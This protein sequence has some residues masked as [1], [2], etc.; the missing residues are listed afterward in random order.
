MRP[1]S[2][3]QLTHDGY[4]DYNVPVIF[5]QGFAVPADMMAAMSHPTRKKR[6]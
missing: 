4:R 5:C 6:G 1:F 2:V 3:C